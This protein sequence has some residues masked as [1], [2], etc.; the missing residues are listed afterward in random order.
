MWIPGRF[1]ISLGMPPCRSAQAGRHPAWAWLYAPPCR[2]G[3]RCAGNGSPRYTT[4]S[5]PATPQKE[6]AALKKWRGN[7][8]HNVYDRKLRSKSSYS[9]REDEFNLLSIISSSENEEIIDLQD[10]RSC[11]PSVDACLV[12]FTL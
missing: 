5:D 6:K 3:T 4:E 9:S 1:H 2:S 11:I 10:W 7:A 8:T 12:S